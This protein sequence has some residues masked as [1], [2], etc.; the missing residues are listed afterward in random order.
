MEEMKRKRE[1]HLQPLGRIIDAARRSK[2]IRA[3]CRRVDAAVLQP[4]HARADLYI[5]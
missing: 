1:T 3:L 5:V 4:D 2:D